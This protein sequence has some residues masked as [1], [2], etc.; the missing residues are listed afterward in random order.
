M[1]QTGTSIWL[2]PPFDLC[3]RRIQRDQIVRPLAPDEDAARARHQQRLP[4][5][6]QVGMRVGITELQTPEEIARIIID[7]LT[8]GAMR[9]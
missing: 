3:W 1:K 2:D 8:E 9:R 4:F 6:Q 7:H 5:Y